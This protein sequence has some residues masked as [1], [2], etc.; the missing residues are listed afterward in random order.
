MT[1]GT[2]FVRTAATSADSQRQ[3]QPGREAAFFAVYV[4]FA[5]IS[6]TL[7]IVTLSSGSLACKHQLAA[8]KRGNDVFRP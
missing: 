3:V 1:R 8:E 2:S 7:W 4:V 5:N 6:S